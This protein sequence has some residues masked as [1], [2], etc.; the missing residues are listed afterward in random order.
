[1][2]DI[3]TESFLTC[4]RCFRQSGWSYIRWRRTQWQ[5]CYTLLLQ[6]WNI[7]LCSTHTTGLKVWENSGE[8][9]KFNGSYLDTERGS[10]S[11]GYHWRS[12]CY[13]IQIQFRALLNDFWCSLS[14]SVHCFFCIFQGFLFYILSFL[15]LPFLHLCIMF[16]CAFELSFSAPVLHGCRSEQ[17]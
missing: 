1:M 13:W 16:S 9:K 14:T 10:R 17:V 6:L 2:K 3:Q 5:C 7:Q 12:W 8:D 11:M 4:L 15:L